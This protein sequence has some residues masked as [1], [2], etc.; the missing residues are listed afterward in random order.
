MSYCIENGEVILEW[1]KQPTV[2]SSLFHNVTS[3]HIHC[4]QWQQHCRYRCADFG[5]F[6]AVT[7]LG[8]LFKPNWDGILLSS[9][10]LIFFCH[11]KWLER[12]T[13][14]HHESPVAHYHLS[15]EESIFYQ[16]KLDHN[17]ITAAHPP[18]SSTSDK[19][20]PIKKSLHSHCTFNSFSKIFSLLHHKYCYRQTP[21]LHSLGSLFPFPK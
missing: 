21:T 2:S 11:V 4:C 16:A 1:S 17:T 3:K 15:S 7:S 14:H 18:Q 9:S 8:H 10:I 5:Y 13:W 12:V 6:I 20:S 19:Q